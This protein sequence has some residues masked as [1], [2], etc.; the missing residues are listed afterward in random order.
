MEWLFGYWP[1]T[2]IGWPDFLSTTGNSGIFDIIFHILV[3]SISFIAIV[4]GF[5]A[6]GANFYQPGIPKITVTTR[7]SFADAGF[8]PDDLMINYQVATAAYGGIYT[9]QG[10]TYSNYNGTVSADAVDDQITAGARAIIFDI[11]PNPANPTLPCVAAMEQNTGWWNTTGGLTKIDGAQL[12]GASNGGFSNWRKLTRNVGELADM[13]NHI[14]QSNIVIQQQDPFFVIF[15]LHGAMTTTYLNTV[16][17]I[18]KKA[19]DGR[20]M[21]TE[22]DKNGGAALLCTAKVSAFTGKIFT[23]ANIVIDSGFQSLPGF[24]SQA[25]INNAALEATT[26]AESINL[27]S[28]SPHSNVVSISSSSAIQST[29]VPGCS[30]TTQVPLNQTTF[31]VLQPTT[32]SI[33][34]TNDSQYTGATSF[35]SCLGTGAQFVG[36]N[37]FDAGNSA[38]DATRRKDQGN[39]TT[40]G[41]FFR[42]K[43]FGST[44]FHKIGTPYY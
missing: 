26:F 28:G 17:G 29:K 27:L 3:L 43:V 34:T 20:R 42:P 6:W 41:D 13:L 23:I 40:L 38:D 24:T 11:W 35:I 1:N 4:I 19:F 15:N 32:G 2:D 39:T 16:G 18:I 30:T 25:D 37:M 22:Y 9:E 33:D 10:R 36:V 7:T 8:S 12:P 31:T 14:Q 21:S 44:G 5:S